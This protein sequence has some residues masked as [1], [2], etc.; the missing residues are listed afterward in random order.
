MI[1]FPNIHVS[2][3][4]LDANSY[5]ATLYGLYCVTQKETLCN[6]FQYDEILSSNCEQFMDLMRI[7]KAIYGN[8][9]FIMASFVVGVGKDLTSSNFSDD[10]LKM[11]SQLREKVKTDSTFL[12]GLKKMSIFD[13]MPLQKDPDNR[14]FL[15]CL[16][17]KFFL[18]ANIVKTEKVNFDTL[19]S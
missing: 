14:L 4:E 7:S 6:I 8:R 19:F 15:L 18:K 12:P 9:S 5:L 3:D 2:A 16:Y 11:F 1:K 10:F 13:I 17:E